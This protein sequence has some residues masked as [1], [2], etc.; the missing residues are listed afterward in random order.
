M[1]LSL[2][3]KSGCVFY[4]QLQFLLQ[5]VVVGIGRE[6]H[7]IEAVEGGRGRIPCHNA[8]P[9][10]PQISAC[11]KTHH[12]CDLGRSPGLPYLFRQNFLGP[13]LPV[14]VTMM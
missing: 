9:T 6:V 4:G 2:N 12:V 14:V 13:L 7:T 8:H 10:A 3:I 11:S 5:L 1:Y